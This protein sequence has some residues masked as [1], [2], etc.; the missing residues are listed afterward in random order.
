MNIQSDK[1]PSSSNPSPVS[2]RLGHRK[3]HRERSRTPRAE[4]KTPGSLQ[5]NL[6]FTMYAEQASSH[7]ADANFYFFK[8]K[9]F[10]RS[11]AEGAPPGRQMIGDALCACEAS[12]RPLSSQHQNLGGA[13]RDRTADPLLA[14]QVLSQLSY[15]P[16]QVSIPD[17]PPPSRARGPRRTSGAPSAGSGRRPRTPRGQT[18]VGPGRLELPTSRLSGVRSNHLSYGPILGRT[19]PNSGSLSFE[20]RETWTAKIAIP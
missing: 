15:S 16:I 8:D 5:I 1:L 14:K 7:S 13:E 11:R 4:P 12:L 20:E 9:D 3:V 10:S 2:G 18:M 6:L 17:R 19:H